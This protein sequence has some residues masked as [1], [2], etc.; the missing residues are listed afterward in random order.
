MQIVFSPPA[1]LSRETLDQA[2]V[3]KEREI[4][5]AQLRNDPKNAKK[6]EEILKKIIEGQLNNFIAGKCLVEL[7]YIRDTS[8]KQ[9]VSQF[10]KA[11]GAGVTIEKFTHIA[12]DIG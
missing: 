1:S 12:T 9:S 11:S 7:P 5:L 6:P 4:L 3:E 8:G 10:L 2:T